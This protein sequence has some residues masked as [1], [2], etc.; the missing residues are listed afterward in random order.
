MAYYGD[1]NV[2]QISFDGGTVWYDVSN[3]VLWD[4]ISISLAAMNDEFRSA[5][6]TAEFDLLYDPALVAEL[7][8][9]DQD[10]LV[11]I[12]HN[13]NGTGVSVA[14][15][16][17]GSLGSLTL[18]GGASAADY[19]FFMG[20]APIGYERSYDGIIINQTFRI[21]ATDSKD[22]LAVPCGDI[23]YRTD[24]THP[25]TICNNADNSLSILHNLVAIAGFTNKIHPDLNIPI[26]IGC[27]APPS[28]DSTVR[29]CIDVLLHEYGYVFFSNE[30]D[31]F[32]A[33]QWIVDDTK[34][35]DFTFNQDNL[36]DNFRETVN[37]RQYEGADITYYEIGQGITTDGDTDVMVYRD[38][39]MA[40]N[41]TIGGFFGYVIISGTT[42][43]PATNVEDETDPPNK[44][45]VYQEYTEDSIQY[46]TNKAIV[47]K[48]DYN[49]EAFSSDFS[50]MLATF[51]H[52]LEYRTD[53]GIV[54][55]TE[56]YENR[57]ARIVLS[58]PTL[59]NLKVY[60]LNIWAKMIYKT[61]QRKS[62]S[63]IGTGLFRK[64]FT[65]E[66]I[67]CNTKEFADQYCIARVSQF[68]NARS[69]YSVESLEKVSI[70]SFCRITLADNTDVKA[71]IVN[72]TF[73]NATGIY[74]YVL[75]KY[76]TDAV[77]LASQDVR[78][79][80]YK[81]NMA[82]SYGGQYIGVVTTP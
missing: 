12:S 3:L 80:S 9:A 24:D 65:Y 1:V 74:K 62:K 70:D 30:Y 75:K 34:P 64:P 55:Q 46:F 15:L 35:T 51:D 10:L 37:V 66:M 14:T 23:V 31:V 72:R 68:K 67:F 82:P 41:D 39:N 59:T 21:Q 77:A 54:L 49:R 17:S 27:F 40:Y 7:E 61:A 38:T 28:E 56:E 52:R 36:L 29:E 47:N 44:V 50:S 18:G 79:L 45:K 53:P 22:L 2:V 78:A 71:M 11:I 20:H 16:G 69:V 13:E 25:Y 8:N 26:D 81:T 33:V 58:N 48:L 32:N 42:Y 19:V 6:N 43:P 5:Q 76:S 57:K 63:G 4:T 73:D 60:Y